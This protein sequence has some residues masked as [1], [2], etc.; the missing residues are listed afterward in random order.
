MKHD[1]SK[2]K[3][4]QGLLISVPIR[5]FMD[6]VALVDTWRQRVEAKQ[7]GVRLV[8]SACGDIAEATVVNA[9]VDVWTGVAAEKVVAKFTQLLLSPPESP[10]WQPWESARTHATFESTAELVII[11]MADAWR[12]LVFARDRQPFQETR[13][14]TGYS[15]SVF[16]VCPISTM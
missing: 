4:H 6:E 13:W 10:L 3:L 11:T 14:H 8:S 12:R 2:E 15:V 1:T 9:T 7:L 5:N 16:H